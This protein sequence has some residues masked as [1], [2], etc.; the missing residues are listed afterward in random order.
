MVVLCANPNPNP[1]SSSYYGGA[2][3]YNTVARG[4]EAIATLINQQNWT[5]LNDD[6]STTTITDA[7]TALYYFDGE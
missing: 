5:Q 6:F 7:T 1:P 4:V 3:C 2:T